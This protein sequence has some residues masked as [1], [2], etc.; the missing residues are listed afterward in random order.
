MLIIMRLKTLELMSFHDLSRYISI[1]CTLLRDTSPF[2][3]KKRQQPSA[4]SF[5]VALGGKPLL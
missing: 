2:E 4:F 3:K 5:F 1:R